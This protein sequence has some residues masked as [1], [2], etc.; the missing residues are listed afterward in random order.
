MLQSGF[1]M[2]MFVSQMRGVSAGK[3]KSTTGPIVEYWCCLCKRSTG[4]L[5]ERDVMG[6]TMTDIHL[7][8]LDWGLGCGW[9]A[10]M[11]Q[12]AGGSCGLA[13]YQRFNPQEHMATSLSLSHHS[14]RW[15]CSSLFAVLF[16][17]PVSVDPATTSWSYAQPGVLFTSSLFPIPFC[18]SCIGM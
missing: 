11:S 12:G 14:R 8:H 15:A 18:F 1:D 5:D 10:Q 4:G 16:P 13:L 2:W 17:L 3:S 7:I 9:A 6:L